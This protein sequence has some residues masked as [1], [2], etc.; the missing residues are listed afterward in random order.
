MNACVSRRFYQPHIS[1]HARPTNHSG[2]SSWKVDRKSLGGSQRWKAIWEIQ[3]MSRS[4]LQCVRTKTDRLWTPTWSMVIW[5]WNHQHLCLQDF[6]SFLWTQISVSLGY[7]GATTFINCAVSSLLVIFIFLLIMI[8]AGCCG[9]LPLTRCVAWLL[10]SNSKL[11]LS[12]I[13]GH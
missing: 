11:W 5:R 3:A 7:T 9:A 13:S 1:I 8:F 10:S 2:F 4:Y 6:W 12:K